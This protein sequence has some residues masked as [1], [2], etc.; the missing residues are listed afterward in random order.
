MIK[1]YGFGFI[2]VVAAITASA[3][4]APKSELADEGVTFHYTEPSSFNQS[5]VQDKAN[6][7][8]NAPQS[9][10]DGES[11]ACELTVNQSETTLISGQRYL[12]NN[13]SAVEGITSGE[14]VPSPSTAG[15][16]SKSDR[17]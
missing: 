3:F 7:S 12:N 1:K 13:I 6:W 2:A 11:K 4:T 17:D 10:D 9:C 14:Y 8:S 5:A 15:Y 16:M